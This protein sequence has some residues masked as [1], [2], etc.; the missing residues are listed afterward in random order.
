MHVQEMCARQTTAQ[1]ALKIPSRQSFVLPATK[2][3]FYAFFDYEL[4]FNFHFKRC[5]SCQQLNCAA[6]GCSDTL[7]ASVKLCMTLCLRCELDM[8]QLSTCDNSTLTREGQRNVCICRL[9]ILSPR[10][11]AERGATPSHPRPTSAWQIPCFSRS[12]QFQ[13][14]L[15]APLLRCR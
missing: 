12:A 13:P 5:F 7:G 8:S 10:L 14:S 1:S 6:G 9:H 15:A 11:P 3:G 2:E 4:S